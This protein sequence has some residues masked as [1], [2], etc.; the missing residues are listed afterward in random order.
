MSEK[1]KI[2]GSLKGL[3]NLEQRFHNLDIC[4]ISIIRW[5]IGRSLR[6]DY[7][8]NRFLE[9]VSDAAKAVVWPLKWCQRKTSNAKMPTSLVTSLG[10]GSKARAKKKG[11]EAFDQTWSYN[12]KDCACTDAN[13]ISSSQCGCCGGQLVSVV[14]SKQ[15]YWAQYQFLP[16][17]FSRNLLF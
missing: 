15:R 9:K 12:L 10:S 11:R 7:L 2:P 5:V 8:I 1:R 13:F 3:G 4:C 6:R 14:G 16:N 17:F